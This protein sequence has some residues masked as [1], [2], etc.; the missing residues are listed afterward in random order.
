MTEL[1]CEYLSV[2][3]SEYRTYLTF[4]KSGRGD[5]KYTRKLIKRELFKIYI[6]GST[7][8]EKYD[9]RILN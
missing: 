7:D 8:L 3:V 2:S 5:T 6:L 9:V 1:C 4:S